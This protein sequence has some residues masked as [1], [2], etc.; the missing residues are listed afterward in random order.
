MSY[1]LRFFTPRPGVDVHDI[2]GNEDGE[3]PAQGKRNPVAEANKRK[4]AD[5]LIAHDARLELFKP[6]FAAIANLHKMRVDEAHERFRHLELNAT[7]SGIQITLT[8]DSASLTIPYWHKGDDA[9]RVLEQAWGLI[10]IV[11]RETNYEVFDGQLDRVI[12]VNAFDDVLRSY[13]GTTQ[14]MEALIG[15]APKKPWW[16][17]W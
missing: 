1:D 11:C 12:D 2:V 9:R 7:A 14:R 17:F 5:A 4:L 3:G 13:A 6:D 15:R 10:E 16:K 8:D